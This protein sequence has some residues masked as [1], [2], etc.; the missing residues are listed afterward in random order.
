[1][2]ELDLLDAVGGVDESYILEASEEKHGKKGMWL[3]WGAAAACLCVIAAAV[4]AV[5]ALKRGAVPKTGEQSGAA[6]VS[7]QQA[8]SDAQPAQSGAADTASQAGGNERLPENSPASNTAVYIPPTALPEIVPEGA[9][10]DM[11]ALVVYRGGIYTQAESYFGADARRVDP[12]V[13]ERLGY[14]TGSI[15][16]WSKQDEYTKE[17]AGSISGDV[18]AVKG[19]DTDF[20]VCVRQEFLN[21]KGEPDLWIQ[22]LD[23]ANGIT[24]E[25]GA[26]LFENR[27]KL[28]ENLE[29]V[30]YQAH[31]DWNWNR[32]NIRE[33]ELSPEVWSAFVEAIDSGAFENT[34]RER[35]QSFY[36]DV[37][38]SSIYDNP[39]QTHLI[40][41]MKDG[42]V[43]RLR[44]IE[45][46]YVGYPYLGWYYVRVP[47]EAFSAVYD[48]CGG[49]HITGWQAGGK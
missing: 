3:K 15:N 10:M 22:F 49:T 25:N 19:Y 30:E 31:E 44:L 34:W 20:R 5:S 40:L 41:R 45:G 43:T 38:G 4:F 18:Y 47:G 11:L 33:A 36:E 7:Q 37:P 1:M 26:A 2:K 28:S 17:F 39:N 24:L 29:S 48:S 14:A 27:L 42:T 16:E 32:G 13:G 35:T 23:R 12:I 46:G 21:E 6:S 9:S 8:D